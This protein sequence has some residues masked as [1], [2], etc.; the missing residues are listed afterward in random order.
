LPDATCR[1]AVLV[2]GGGSNLEAIL[3]AQ[4]SG[5]LPAQVVLVLS[6]RS[7]AFALERAKRRSIPTAVIERKLFVSESAY[8]A[9]VLATVQRAEPHVICL[10]GYLKKLSPEFIAAYR[11]RILNIHPALLPKFGGAGMYGRFVHQAVLKSGDQDSGCTVHL[12]DEEFD[13]GPTLA[14]ARVPILP[15]DTEETLAA[16][17]L[18]E[19]HRLYPQ[20]IRIFCEKL[21]GKQSEPR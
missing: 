5:E 4:E 3:Q 13:H 9:A 21:L 19:E 10:A 17:V 16:R 18:A 1:I 15:D 8:Q 14:Q 6:S 7:D 12:V 20:T 11:G 2:S